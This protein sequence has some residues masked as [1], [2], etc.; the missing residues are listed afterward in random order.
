[1]AVS[2]HSGL[3]GR[4]SLRASAKKRRSTPSQREDTAPRA[5]PQ[6]GRRCR[7]YTKDAGSR[8][9]FT[10]LLS[11]ADDIDDTT[12]GACNICP[13]NF[14]CPEDAG[15]LDSQWYDGIGQLAGH[16]RHRYHSIKQAAVNGLVASECFYELAFKPSCVVIRAHHP[17]GDR[18]SLSLS[19]VKVEGTSCLD[20]T[21]CC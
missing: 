6:L 1:M 5:L 10:D 16:V 8:S 20:A 9:S 2:A 4:N 15:I 7:H 12:E 18:H 14:G 11:S 13:G 3:K 21:S 17:E 19:G